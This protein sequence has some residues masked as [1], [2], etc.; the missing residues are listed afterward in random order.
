MIKF[1]HAGERDA[2][3]RVAFGRIVQTIPRDE[4]VTPASI[5]RFIRRK[6]GK[7]PTRCSAATSAVILSMRS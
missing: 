6:R 1:D 7:W 2:D 3:A 4:P 5:A